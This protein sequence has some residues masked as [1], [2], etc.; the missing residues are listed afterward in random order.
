MPRSSARR[1][2]PNGESETSMDQAMDRT[3]LD[4]AAETA[5]ALWRAYVIEPTDEGAQ[6]ILDAL[7]PCGLSIIGTGKHEFYTSLESFLAG[8]ELD[9]QE[10]QNVTFEILDEYYEPQ[11]I[12]VDTCIVFG[13]LWVR[14][15][16]VE[17][18][19]LLVEMD[20]R[21]TM[22]L[23]RDG[24][25][26]LMAHLHHS[27]PNMDQRREEYYPKT[28]TEQANAALEYS[29]EMERRAQ[30]DSMT[31]L[32]NHAAFEK[33]VCAALDRGCAGGAFFMIDLDN[34]KL[35][36]DTLGHPEGDRV[37][38]EFADLLEQVFPCDALVARMGG[39][40]FAVLTELPL[41]VGEVEGK[42]RQLV[43]RW[44]ACSEGRPVQLGCSVGL[45]TV[46]A[47]ATF[48]DLYRAADEAL[49][50]SKRKGKG[51]FSW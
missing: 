41:S 8:L 37:I 51:R 7:D 1:N 14:E 47:D 33:Q 28:A 50:V 31:E 27:T 42:A 22:V 45:A 15:K 44:R 26:W 39:D 17:A 20:T 30:L 35:V 5:R 46:G 38:V 16:P 21:F 6:F 49:Y 29:R 24:D 3:W 25:R 18:K 48:Y 23:R 34:F 2:S 19:P 11:A 9:Q 12:G 43:D 13:T 40:E 32:L 10:A 36:N 4:Q